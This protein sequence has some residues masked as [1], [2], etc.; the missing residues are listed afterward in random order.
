MKTL[1]RLTPLEASEKATAIARRLAETTIMK[2]WDWDLGESKPDPINTEKIGKTPRH[3]V[4]LVDY[5]K[6]G[7]VLDGPAVIRV[8]LQMESATWEVTP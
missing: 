3:W 5:K 8:D 1:R 2:G 7:S 6:G 4:S